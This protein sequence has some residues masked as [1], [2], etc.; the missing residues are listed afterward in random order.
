M[1]S[2]GVILLIILANLFIPGAQAQRMT[3]QNFKKL[4]WLNGTWKRTN[5]KPDHSGTEYWI[6]TAPYKMEGKG[7]SLKGTDT[8]FVENLKLTINGNCIFYIVEG[9]DNQRPVYFKM[10][11]ITDKSFICENQLHD[12]P[13]KIEYK[14][15]GNTITA[16][17]SGD[18]KSID[19]IF[20]KET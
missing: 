2:A 5:V 9:A 15:N 10:T 14:L 17:I 16:T 12:F 8:V 18:G 3:K 6:K 7:F 19:F 13:K 11:A 4:Y 20:I 1:K